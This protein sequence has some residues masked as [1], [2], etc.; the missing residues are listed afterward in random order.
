MS[1]ASNLIYNRQFP[2]RNMMMTFES[3]SGAQRGNLRFVAPFITL[4]QLRLA[5][6]KVQHSPG[7][8]KKLS[9][10]SQQCILILEAL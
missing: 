8:T 10:N 5:I 1:Q 6:F 3:L 7:V 2:E 9:I 4:P